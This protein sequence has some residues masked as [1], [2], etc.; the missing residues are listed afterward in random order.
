LKILIIDDD[1]L[2]LS[3]LETSLSVR[4]Y[5][6]RSY[7]SPVAAI[8]AFRNGGFD[9]V[10]TAARMLEISGGEVLESILGIDPEAR[11]IF[12]TGFDDIRIDP[13]IKR[14]VFGFFR[15]PVVIEELIDKIE[16]IEKAQ[17]FGN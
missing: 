15:K 6:C 2:H 1:P 9:A 8:D 7:L 16:R 11:V 5:D 13:D 12:I 10:I 17:D 4:G 3:S 14:E